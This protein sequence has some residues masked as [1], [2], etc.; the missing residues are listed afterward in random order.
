M[1]NNPKILVTGA[2]GQLGMEMRDLAPSYPQFEFLF[3]GK[4]ELPI[5]NIVELQNFFSQHQPRY[6]INCAAYTAV[7][8]AE[9]PEEKTKAFNINVTAA[10]QLSRLC[11]EY[12]TQLI[13]ISTDYVF[14]GTASKPYQEDDELNP[15]NHYGLTKFL[16][17]RFV[18][19]SGSSIV[20]RTSWLYSSY[21]KNFVKTMLRV[22]SEKDQIQV[23]NDQQG[24]PTYA[25]DLGAAIL[26]IIS[27]GKW[28]AGVYHFCNKGVISWYDFAVAI[29]EISGSSC[30]IESIPTSKFP[31]PAKRPVY[32]VLNTQKIE[33]VYGIK[34]K[35]WKESLKRCI[36][37]L[38]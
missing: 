32:S 34:T 4:E 12:R 31:T 20:I 29:K 28:E 35:D 23:V 6:C 14:D 18:L 33:Q 26:Q 2:H 11:L 21:G 1:G 8:K 25:A 24:S 10:A 15:L 7:D 9:D 16:G 38:H 30:K 19:S 27:S 37:N 13:H 3:T 22:M 36:D 5:E 17:E